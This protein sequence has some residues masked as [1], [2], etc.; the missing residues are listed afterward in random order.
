MAV[1]IVLAFLFVVFGVLFVVKQG[2]KVTPPSGNHS[3]GGYTGGSNN[4]PHVSDI[5]NDD[6]PVDKENPI[7]NG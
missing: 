7:D 3:G 1:V 4:H 2:N 5:N 6:N